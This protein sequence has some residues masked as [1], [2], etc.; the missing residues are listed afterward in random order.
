MTQLWLVNAQVNYPED[1]GD[2][3]DHGPWTLDQ[4][5]QFIRDLIE[6]HKPY[7]ATSFTFILV[8]AKAEDQA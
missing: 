3:L 8:P 2:A 1:E 5:N 4:V 6:A 7:E